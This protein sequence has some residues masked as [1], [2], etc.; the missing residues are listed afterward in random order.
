MY[1]R[2][3]AALM[4]FP[5]DASKT[6][7]RSTWHDIDLTDLFQQN[8]TGNKLMGAEITIRKCT[9][10]KMGVEIFLH[11]NALGSKVHST[12]ICISHPFGLP[13]SLL[14]T[15]CLSH[16]SGKPMGVHP[17]LFTKLGHGGQQYACVVNNGTSDQTCHSL[18][19]SPPPWGN[20]HALSHPP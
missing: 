13:A 5:T 6:H 2:E 9:G 20:Q 12:S 15:A 19:C 14:C 17:T 3:Y 11:L 1:D 18:M 8:D 4:K 16:G 10:T 7:A